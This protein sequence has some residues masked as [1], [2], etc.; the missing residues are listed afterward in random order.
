[1]WGFG[2]DN[3]K[4]IVLVTAVWFTSCIIMRPRYLEVIKNS[5][6][7]KEFNEYDFDDDEEIV[8]KLKIGNKLPVAI[9]YD[10]EEEVSRIIGEKSINELKGLI[11]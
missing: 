8:D 7:V 6:T 2:E 10:G 11:G 3:M 1:M 9:I 5:N 4:K